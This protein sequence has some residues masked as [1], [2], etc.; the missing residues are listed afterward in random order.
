M[1]QLI[2]CQQMPPTKLVVTFFFFPLSGLRYLISAATGLGCD[3]T[4]FMA[5]PIRLCPRRIGIDPCNQRPPVTTV[6]VLL[7]RQ[8]GQLG[9]PPAALSLLAETCWHRMSLH[10]SL[11]EGVTCLIR[12]LLKL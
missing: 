1:V 11:L 7:T 5:D 3:D 9:L 10:P 8:R 12:T 4:G 2:A 6:D